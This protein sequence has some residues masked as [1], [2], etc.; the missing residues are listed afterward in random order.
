[1]DEK[2]FTELCEVRLALE[3]FA[4]GQ[5]AEN[6]TSNE[7]RLIQGTF[8]QF[9][10]L[11]EQLLNDPFQLSV[12]E[13]LVKADVMFHMAIIDASR[14]SMVRREVERMNLIRQVVEGR[15]GTFASVIET[16]LGRQRDASHLRGV[17]A[18][19]SAVLKAI[20]SRDVTAARS[21]MEEH[22]KDVIIRKGVAHPEDLLSRDSRDE[23]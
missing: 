23:L 22:I 5:A 13:Q 18:S 14:N 2:E 21:A 15:T 20:E 12:R 8:D 6:R 19:H 1:M 4:A 17:Q 7:M 10:K 16:E 9:K 3:S 11:T